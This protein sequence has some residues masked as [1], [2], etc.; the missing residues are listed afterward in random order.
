MKICEGAHDILIR[1]YFLLFLFEF[2]QFSLQLNPSNIRKKERLKS[3]PTVFTAFMRARVKDLVIL[4][5]VTGL[6]N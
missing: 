3:T 4:F 1:D 2:F 6:D 5:P